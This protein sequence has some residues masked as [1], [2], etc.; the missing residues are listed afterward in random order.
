MRYVGVLFGLLVILP[1]LGSPAGA[2]PG[3]KKQSTKRKAAKGSAT[4]SNRPMTQA[5]ID[6]F[7]Q[8]EAEKQLRREGKVGRPPRP[9]A[10]VEAYLRE[11]R[12]ANLRVDQ[13]AEAARQA[14]LAKQAELARR[15]A[16]QRAAGEHLGS[17]ASSVG[18]YNRLLRRALQLNELLIDSIRNGPIEDGDR[19]MSYVAEECRCVEKAMALYGEFVNDPAF[20]V[21][22]VETTIVFGRWKAMP[23]YPGMENLRFVEPR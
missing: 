16:E 8:A 6:A 10:E 15:A 17:L 3:A 4:K 11:R 2:Q 19:Q 23:R 18:E 22:Y 9:D 7:L 21:R 5:E 13:R 12:E 14:E 20:R 1:V